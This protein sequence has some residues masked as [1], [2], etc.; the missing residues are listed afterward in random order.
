MQV[1]WGKEAPRYSGV[2]RR[3]QTQLRLAERGREQRAKQKHPQLQQVP[4]RFPEPSQ[5]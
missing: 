5:Q 2:E 4:L 3:P 1:A